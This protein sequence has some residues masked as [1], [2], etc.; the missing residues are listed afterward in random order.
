MESEKF[1]A[2]FMD[3]MKDG[4]SLSYGDV[5]KEFKETSFEFQDEEVFIHFQDNS[6]VV[7]TP[8]LLPMVH[9]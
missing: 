1:V 4:K 2:W 7:F 6:K 5:S 8:E 3:R 9:L